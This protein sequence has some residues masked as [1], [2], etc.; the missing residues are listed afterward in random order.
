[1]ATCD[2]KLQ[3]MERRLN[4][5]LTKATV[6]KLTKAPLSSAYEQV[7][8]SIQKD[9]EIHKAKTNRL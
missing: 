1:M 7:I 3:A 4:W 9:I 2:Y 8:K 5:L 6:A